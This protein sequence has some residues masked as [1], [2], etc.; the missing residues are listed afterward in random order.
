MPSV[1]NIPEFWITQ[2]SKYVSGSECARVL[3]I[4]DFWICLWFWISQSSEYARVTQG[5]EYSWIIPGYAWICLNISRYVFICL[6]MLEYA[7]IC[8]N[9]LCFTFPVSLFL[10]QSLSHLSTWFL[11]W[12]LQETRGY[13]MKEHEA[14]FLKRKNLI[15][16]IAAGYT[17]LVFCFF[18]VKTCKEI[19]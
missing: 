9:G 17:L 4:P 3:D 13:H 18:L 6:N 5:S 1:L 14:V 10:L 15:F 12:D 8:L 2:D 16:S 7:Y 11:I 19:A